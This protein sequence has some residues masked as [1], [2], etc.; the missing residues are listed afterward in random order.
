M[1][2]KTAM[3]RSLFT[4]A[5]TPPEKLA[6]MMCVNIYDDG[7]FN[8]NGK[9]TNKLG[10]KSLEIAFTEDGAHF[11]LMETTVSDFAVCFPK[12]GSRKLPAVIEHLKKQKIMLPVNSKGEPDYKYMEDYMKYL[13][14]KKLL[15]YLEYIK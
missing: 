7:K 14:Q 12:T 9:L 11:I 15:E 10:G 2:K 8:M 13:E 4:H 1:K 6:Q 3:N 5:I